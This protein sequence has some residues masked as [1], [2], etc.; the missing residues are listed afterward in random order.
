MKEAYQIT[1]NH[2]KTL[3]KNGKHNT[4]ST[5]QA[6]EY[7]IEIG[8]SEIYSNTHTYRRESK[9]AK[10]PRKREQIVRNQSGRTSKKPNRHPV[11]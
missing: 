9:I 2:I 8:H 3:Y 7:H 6:W 4:K 10:T 5:D 1:C 11:L